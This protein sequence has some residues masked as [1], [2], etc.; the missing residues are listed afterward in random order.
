MDAALTEPLSISSQF[1]FCSLPLRLDS[2]RGCAFGCAY[3]FAMQRGGNTA[4]PKIAPSDPKVVAKC[5]GRAIRE[6]MPRSPLIQMLQR[7]V[8]IHFGGMSDPFQPAERKWQITKQYLQAMSQQR[9]PVVISTKGSLSANPEYQSLY[10]EIGSV[11]VQFSFSSIDDAVA[12]VVEPTAER[13][14]ALLR[15]ME[16]LATNGINVTCRWQ[17]YI[18]GVSG[19]A[20][21]FLQSVVSAGARHVAIEHLKVPTERNMTTLNGRDNELLA[22]AKRNYVA[23]GARRDG[24]ELIL[25]TAQKIDRVLQV[26]ELCHASKVT[27]GAA[28]NE[29]QY[30]SDTPACCSG[31]DQFSGFENVFKF[32]IGVA[33]RQSIGTDICYESIA[34]EWKPTGSIDRYLNSQSRIGKRLGV[35]GSIQDHI[36]HKWND[37]KASGNPSSFEGIDPTNERSAGGH[38]RYRWRHALEVSRS[39]NDA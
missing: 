2:Y 14:S 17:P 27:F 4:G 12:E 35:E 19:E 7:R 5:F 33:V 15:A 26:R 1:H 31:V 37:L 36:E 21:T 8:P 25:P 10:H 38:R 30:L 22:N 24:R 23:A 18:P 13:P 29:L 6:E 9:Y 28:D 32:N 20:R 39:P 11:V 16:S 34:S 3:C